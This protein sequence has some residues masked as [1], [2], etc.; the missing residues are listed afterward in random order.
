MGIIISLSLFL[1]VVTHIIN[2]RKKE[3]DARKIMKAGFVS[4]KPKANKT[5]SGKNSNRQKSPAL[6]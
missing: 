1:I 2:Q 4:G 5:G 3:Q 6:T